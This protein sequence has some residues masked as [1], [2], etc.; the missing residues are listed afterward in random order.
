MDLNPCGELSTDSA[1]LGAGFSTHA[2]LW[3]QKSPSEEVPDTL[4]SP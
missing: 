3:H 2:L 4:G 1:E